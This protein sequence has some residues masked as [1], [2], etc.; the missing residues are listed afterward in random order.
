[1]RRIAKAG[2]GGAAE[3]VP[4]H[5]G[6]IP[7]GRYPVSVHDPEDS[8]SPPQCRDNLGAASVVAADAYTDSS[9]DKGP[10]PATR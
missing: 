2:A 9:P 5:S 6:V 4:E 7:V 10:Y 3:G 1:M 8:A